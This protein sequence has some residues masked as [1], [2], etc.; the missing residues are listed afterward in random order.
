MCPYSAVSDFL[1]PH[2]LYTGFSREEYQGGLPFPPLGDLPDPGIELASPA[3][4]IGFFTTA[5]LGKPC[6]GVTYL[7]CFVR[8]RIGGLFPS[9]GFLLLLH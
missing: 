5:P 4:A 3:L 1:Q 2:G 7:A 9:T 8:L 6:L